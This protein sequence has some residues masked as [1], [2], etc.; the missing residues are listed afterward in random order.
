MPPCK[1][2]EL[3][4]KVQLAPGGRLLQLKLTVPLNEL[5]AGGDVAPVMAI[6]NSAFCPAVIVWVLD[7]ISVGHML[8]PKSVKPV[9]FSGNVWG[10][11]EA[12]SV[13]VICPVLVPAAVGAKVNPLRLEKSAEPG[14]TTRGR[15]FPVAVKSE[16]VTVML[17]IVIAVVP[18]FER[19]SPTEE[20]S[21]TCVAPPSIVELG[22]ITV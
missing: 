7:T 16:P 17:V 18:V 22:T 12:S 10:L 20:L 2:I 14:W 5:G 4:E 9:P 11:P 13:K 15:A 19:Q 6:K 8:K 1:L 3:G 21:P